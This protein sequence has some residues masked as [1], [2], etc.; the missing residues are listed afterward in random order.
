MSIEAQQKGVQANMGIISWLRRIVA[1]FFCANGD[2]LT[3]ASQQAQAEIEELRGLTIFAVAHARRTELELR[4]IMATDEPDQARLAWLVPRLEEERAR[5][6]ALVERYRQRQ[7][8]EAE[9]LERLGE[10][11]ATEEITRREELRRSIGRAGEALSEEELTGLEDEARGE[12]SRLDV[13]E[14]LEAGDAGEVTAAGG[15]A[16]VDLVARAQRLLDG[17]AIER[18]LTED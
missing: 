4:E 12:A 5:A 15:L 18:P 16:D 9:R 7:E 17:P 3:L 1:D 13:L 8:A 14:H 10:L 2:E 11:R 6:A